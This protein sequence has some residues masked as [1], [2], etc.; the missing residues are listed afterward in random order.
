MV[1]SRDAVFSQKPRA[2]YIASEERE[3]GIYVDLEERQKFKYTKSSLSLQSI[4]D[5]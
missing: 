4:L 3:Q 5:V 1:Y 2:H